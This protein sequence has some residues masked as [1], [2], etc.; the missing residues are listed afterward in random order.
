MTY[1]ILTRE[2]VENLEKTLRRAFSELDKETGDS[3][4]ETEI[5]FQDLDLGIFNRVLDYL[6]NATKN[7]F[8]VFHSKDYISGNGTRRT[9]TTIPDTQDP[10]IGHQVLHTIKKNSVYTDITSLREWGLK[11]AISREEQIE[12]VEPHGP[13]SPGR[14]KLVRNKHRHS[15]NLYDQQIRI[16]LTQVQET[17]DN[18]RPL[19]KF[20]VEVELVDT[21]NIN[22]RVWGNLDQVLVVLLKLVQH[23]VCIYTKST[24]ESLMNDINQILNSGGAPSYRGLPQRGREAGGFGSN[25]KTT[26]PDVIDH[27]TLVQ[28]RNLKIRDLVWGGLMGGDVEY[29]C[30]PKAE[31]LRKMFVIHETGIWLVFPPRE[32]CQLTLSNPKL[33]V[34]VGTILDGEDLLPTH[35]KPQSG[36][37]ELH[38]YLPFDTIAIR[39]SIAIQEQPHLERLKSC[40][41]IIAMFPPAPVTQVSKSRGF[42]LGRKDFDLLG[43]TMND[44]YNTMSNM[45]AKIRQLQYHTDGYMFTPNNAPY[46]PHSDQHR[47][48]QRIL[49]RYPDIC[50]WKAPNKLTIDLRLNWKPVT[51]DISDGLGVLLAN[52]KGVP[53]VFRGSSKHPFNPAT[54]MMWDHPILRDVTSGMIIEL[55]PDFTSDPIRLCPLR[56][57]DEKPQPNRMEIAQD[58]WN[59]INNPLDH[60]ILLG[61][62]SFALVRAYHNRVKKQLLSEIPVGAF[63]VDLGSGRG[64][65]VYKWAHLGQVLAVEPNSDHTKE[66]IRRLKNAVIADGSLMDKKV[67]VEVCGGE[68]TDR[69]VRAAK[70]AFGLPQVSA[71]LG[72]QVSSTR[73]LPPMYISMMLS[74]SFFWKSMDFLNQLA[75]TIQSLIKM[76]HD[77]GG[78]H[79]VGFKFL[80]IEGT[81]VRT[82]FQSNSNPV[83]LGPANIT[84]NNNVVN[85]H[86]KDTIVDNQT[87][88]L[89]ELPQL[90]T[91]AGLAST[92]LHYATDEKF[93]SP[94]ELI[95]TG[96]YCYGECFEIPITAELIEHQRLLLSGVESDTHGRLSPCEAHRDLSSHERE[97]PHLLGVMTSVDSVEGHLNP[98]SN[99]PIGMPITRPLPPKIRLQGSHAKSGSNGTPIDNRSPHQ[100]PPPLESSLRSA[101][102]DQA[103]LRSA[104]L[105]KT[106]NHSDLTPNVEHGL[107]RITVVIPRN[108]NP[109]SIGVPVEPYY[110]MEI[111][112]MQARGDDTIERVNIATVSTDRECVGCEM[113]R[114][115][116][117]R[118]CGSFFH[119]LLK[120]VDTNYRRNGSWYYRAELVTRLRRDMAIMLANLNPHSDNI[121]TVD[122]YRNLDI[123]TFYYTL[124][125]GWF[126]NRFKSINDAQEWIVSGAELTLQEL[127]WIPEMVELNLIILGTGGVKRIVTSHSESNNW[128]LIHVCTDGTFESLALKTPDDPN[129]QTIFR[130]THPIIR[131][132]RSNP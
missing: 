81:A 121:S 96:L 79:P 34:L 18:G 51:D 108:Q 115:S 80:T 82:L 13:V 64:G 75:T 71:S 113:Y 123:N 104:P 32:Y 7:K 8:D 2:L 36:I 83:V 47:L 95:Y 1:S 91:L 5:R 132:L 122:P 116:V 72:T 86:I 21:R 126:R 15:F 109:S 62:D 26:K 88:Y 89:V 129:L 49:T 124:N 6:K 40:N 128:S 68:E 76:Y 42:A 118:E 111:A 19:E 17:R 55:A 130:V 78:R 25:P 65:D 56:I 35:R 16:D 23:T 93:L 27:T 58:V 61:E 94:N 41:Q 14:N 37:T 12:I 77:A 54:Q 31:G 105:S 3:L 74:L 59:D 38:Y 84:L 73:D 48:N 24:R 70:L 43:S 110:S 57:R 60:N 99:H 46:N 102:L 87:E 97:E 114:I 67:H 52:N 30:T 90:W 103:N 92:K 44:F 112:N 10:Q 33:K 4:I 98:T 11:I 9:A 63:L 131:I 100:G 69:I 117:I 39:G 66:L 53:T 45:D 119:S 120:N 101:K 85:I 50:K 22:S 127:L 20:E 28:A 125:N 29:T 106:D 107:S